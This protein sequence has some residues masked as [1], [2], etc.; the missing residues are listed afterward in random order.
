MGL[1]VLRVLMN[2]VSFFFSSSGL[3]LLK[4]LVCES[5]VKM[6]VN[7]LMVDWFNGYVGELEQIKEDFQPLGQSPVWV[8][9][10]LGTRVMREVLK[11]VGT[12]YSSR[13]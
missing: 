2:R 3:R 4:L 9:G 8:L 13:D 5:C 11:R 10:F 7:W 12:M 6:L 1:L